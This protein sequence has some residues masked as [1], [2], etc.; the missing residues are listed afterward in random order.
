FISDAIYLPLTQSTLPKEKIVKNCIA[1]MD[2]IPQLLADA[3]SN[4]RNPPRVMTETAIRQNRGT[5]AFFEKGLFD[6]VGESGQQAELKSA[7]SRAVEALKEYQKFLEDELLSSAKGDWRM[8]KERFLK[9]LELELDAGLTAEQVRAEAESEFARV[10]R[11]MYIV[12]R[13]L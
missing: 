3:R 13:Q 12:A 10:E 2:A 6:L 4:L 9:K 7:A 5:I 11:D 1:R 8:G